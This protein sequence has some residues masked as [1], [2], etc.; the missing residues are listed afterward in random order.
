MA[1]NSIRDF[2]ATAASNTDIQSVDI[3]ENCAA[4]GI[5]NAI[6]ELMADL[7]DVNAGTVAMTSPSADSLS[8][9]TIS[10][11]TSGSGVTID[12]VLLK[13]GALGSIASAVAAHLTSINGGQIGGNRNLIINGDMQCWQRA[14]AAT[15]AANG[16]STVDRWYMTENTDGAYTTERSTDHPFGS[17]YSLKCQVTTADTSLSAGQ[18]AFLDHYIEAQNLQ[19]LNYGTSD[20]KS[21]TLS[22]WVKSNKTGT[23]T[24]SLYKQDTTAYMYTKEYTISS[25]NTWEKKTITISPT[26]GSTSFITSSGGAI[27]NDNGLGLGLAHGLAWGSNFTGGTSDSWSSTVA[28][29]STTNH[30][31]WM[32]S[33]SNNFYLAQVQLE[34]GSTAT[35][36][37]HESY[38]ET[39]AK[40]QRYYYEIGGTAANDFAQKGYQ[41]ANQYEM[42]TLSHP[43]TMRAA[44]TLTKSGTFNVTNIG[45][46]TAVAA[47][48]TN[49]VWQAQ[50]N[51]STGA[52]N[53]YSDSS[54]KFTLDAEL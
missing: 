15:A 34:V 43:T 16:Y 27:A 20:A 24:I 21:L 10:E 19:H 25:A 54:G 9:D 14:T 49:F 22:F 39:L 32:D 51:G 41:A 7:A 48:I 11:K 17:G 8:T 4:S 1:K 37:Q 38:G 44:P 5:N 6:R 36:F 3:D 33:T 42:N 29:Y 47:S 26:A 45:Q 23:Y 40:C 50:K 2:S 13:D 52:W 31:N 12:S 53:F 35:E 46:P 28:N 30:V 18:S